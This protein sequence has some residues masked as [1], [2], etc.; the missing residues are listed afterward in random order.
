MTEP[1]ISSTNGGASL[2]DLTGRVALITGGA[3]LL[4]VQHALAIH[5][6]GGIPVLADL[7][8]TAAKAAASRV[9]E[10]AVGIRLDV[11]VPASVEQACASLV[12]R[13]GKVHIL[14][15]NAARNPKVEANPGGTQLGR[16]EDF[17]LNAWNLDV[18]VGLTG[19]ILCSRTFG[20]QMAASGGGVILNIA[21]DLA[22]IGPDQRLYEKPGLLPEQQP[23][24]P[25]SYSVVKAGLLGLT[26]YLATYW[27][28]KEV[29]A[30]AICPGGV[31]AGQPPEFLHRISQLIPL[32]RMAGASEYHGAVVFL[33]SDASA[34][35][36]GSVIS[37]D[38]GRTAW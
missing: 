17:D 37:V 32:G 30:N 6:Q 36:T 24:K 2:F 20:G 3:G 7:D 33:C 22:L 23:K 27:A 15:N 16:F 34:Y 14:I 25:V 11:T 21:S 1:A 8:E 19:A 31:E 12:G 35:M 5:R 13:F 9:G 26:R 10:R 18:A 38:G 4:G 29:R 28:G